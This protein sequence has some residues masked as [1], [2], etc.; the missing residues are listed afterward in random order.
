MGDTGEDYR[1]LD[2][3][4]KERRILLGVPCPKCKESRPRAHAKILLPGQ[5]CWCGYRDEREDERWVN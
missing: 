1:A 5:K 2:A 3:H 4:N